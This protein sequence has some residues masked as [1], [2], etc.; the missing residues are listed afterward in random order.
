[1]CC[2]AGVGWSVDVAQ[3]NKL[4]K[5]KTN[6]YGTGHVKVPT[7]HQRFGSITV[8]VC[9]VP[10]ILFFFLYSP[11]RIEC[12]YQLAIVVKTFIRGIYFVGISRKRSIAS[13]SWLFFMMIPKT[14]WKLFSRLWKLLPVHN[15]FVTL[16]IQRRIRRNLSQEPKILILFNYYLSNLLPRHVLLCVCVYFVCACFDA[17]PSLHRTHILS[18]SNTIW[19]CRVC[20]DLIILLGLFIDWC[21]LLHSGFE[22]P[23]TCINIAAIKILYFIAK[24][25][26]CIEESIKSMVFLIA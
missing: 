25:K 22:Y 9:C 18:L 10:C 6:P 15:P 21:N 23:K 13:F 7:A 26:I 24:S 11:Q 1:M 4:D 8:W 12:I 14:S 17:L 2:L 16:D 3:E 19:N 20:S 5:F